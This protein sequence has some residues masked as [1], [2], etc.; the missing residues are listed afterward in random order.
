MGKITARPKVKL[1]CGF[2]YSD[3]VFFKQALL[4]LEKKYGPSDFISDSISFK[5]TKYY[6]NEMGDIPL[7]KKISSF[8]GL[9]D[10]EKLPLIKKQTN[11]IECLFLNKNS[12][13]INIDP[14]Y[15]TA[16][17]L[18]LASTKNQQ[19]RIYL[20][21][22]IYAEHELFFQNKTFTPWPW[23]Y[24]DYTSEKYIQIFNK[25]RSIYKTQ[26]EQINE[27]FI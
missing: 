4:H 11:K 18:I 13:K 19:H 24:P 14:G 7:F 9:I 21:D 1:I 2:I 6:N 12:R 10:A 26:I 3:E 22:G 23:T 27:S 8:K 20:S 15:I 5:H 25:L 16:A 17:K